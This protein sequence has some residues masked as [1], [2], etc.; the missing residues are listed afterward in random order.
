MCATAILSEMRSVIVSTH[1]S[2]TEMDGDQDP[3]L[4]QRGFVNGSDDT[5]LHPPRTAASQTLHDGESL[6]RSHKRGGSP[7][8]DETASPRKYSKK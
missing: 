3:R 6:P 4:G 8:L 7:S 1:D 5:E 2:D